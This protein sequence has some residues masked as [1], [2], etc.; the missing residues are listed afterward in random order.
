MPEKENVEQARD[1]QTQSRNDPDHQREQHS[2][3]DDG[4]LLVA[5]LNHDLD[6]EEELVKARSIFGSMVANRKELGLHDGVQCQGVDGD[7]RTLGDYDKHSALE[8]KVDEESDVVGALFT[9]GQFGEDQEAPPALAAF[10]QSHTLQYSCQRLEI[11]FGNT[12]CPH[13]AQSHDPSVEKENVGDDDSDCENPFGNLEGNLGL[14]LTRPFIEGEKVD[15]GESIGGVDSAG[16]DYE[17]P[18]PY[19]GEGRETG[20]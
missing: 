1:E 7:A 20:C 14:D 11:T 9:L 10:S 16:D 8:L 2:E 3:V 19:I 13:D 18:Q 15:G 12:A 6:V 5:F 17:D 4:L